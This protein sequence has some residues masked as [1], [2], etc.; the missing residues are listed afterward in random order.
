[1]P[2]VVAIIPARLASSRLPRK[3]LL[4]ET[5]KP[6]IQHVYEA[7][8]RAAGIDLVVVATDHQEVVEACDGFGAKAVLTSESC[9]SGTDRVAEAAA[10]FPEAKIVLNVQG[11]EPEMDPRVLEALVKVMREDTSDAEMGTVATPW[12]AD[13]S[14]DIPG[15]VKVV[16]N[17]AMDAMYFSRS[18]IPYIRDVAS[19]SDRLAPAKLASSAQRTRFRRHVGLYAFRGDA[20]ARFAAMPPSPLEELEA[21]EQLRALDAG[22][23]IRVA[24]V[25]YQGMEVNTPEDYAAFVERQRKKSAN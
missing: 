1:M 10:H 24:E 19:D 25:D 5:G 14:L 6:L 13:L 11:D 7:T 20:L 17:S 4:N 23:R 16:C 9:A 3:V 15:C 2:D 12:P 21:L 8:A 18:P 22:W